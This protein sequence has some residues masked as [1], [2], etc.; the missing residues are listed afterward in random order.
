MDL[1]CNLLWLL[2]RFCAR[3]SFRFPVASDGVDVFISHCQRA[4]VGVTCDG[5]V[6]ILVFVVVVV[7]VALRL[8]K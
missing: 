7:L 5:R 8:V 3:V 2:L 1:V 6:A 4:S